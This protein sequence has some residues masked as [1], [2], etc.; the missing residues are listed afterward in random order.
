MGFIGFLLTLVL[1][2]CEGCP[3]AFEAQKE[4]CAHNRRSEASCRPYH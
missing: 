1:W 4:D 2:T 3:D